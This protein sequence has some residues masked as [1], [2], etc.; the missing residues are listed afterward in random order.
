MRE[1]LEFCRRVLRSTG[2]A[3][4]A[5][6]TALATE[7]A[8]RLELLSAASRACRAHVALDVALPHAPGA[9]G[10][11][12]GA[13]ARELAAATAR[14]PE[15]QREALALRDAI[16]LSHSELAEVARIDVA[17]V[18]SLLARARMRLREELRGSEP[19]L[20]HVCGERDR[21]LRSLA[22]R[23]DGEAVA[24]EDREWLSDHLAGCPSCRRAHAA[25]LEASICYRAWRVD[26]VGANDGPE[27]L[28]SVQRLSGPH[29]EQKD[30]A[31][32]ARPALWS[33]FRSALAADAR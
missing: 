4:E 30:H 10:G 22:R 17:A 19:S 14:L 11:L 8:D 16:G 33:R 32:S 27:P 21:A 26:A 31:E 9:D 12:D 29:V 5:A 3:Q 28:V 6:R 15:R 13:V 2:A 1:T 25:M 18:G 24:Q 7:P 23:Q 20:T